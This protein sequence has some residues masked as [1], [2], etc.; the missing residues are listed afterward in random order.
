MEK[1]N[2]LEIGDIPN[3]YTYLLSYIHSNN[4]D[5]EFLYV[6]EFRSAKILRDF[7][8]VI[9][10]HFKIDEITISRFILIVDELNNNAIEHGSKKGDINKLRF[11]IFHENG[12][13]NVQIEV[14]DSGR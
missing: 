2:L 8:D 6:S 11:K 3:K 13:Q 12:F 1:I 4:L 7:V 14:E 9:C 5:I 10:R